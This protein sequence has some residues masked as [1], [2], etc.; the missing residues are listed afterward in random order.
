MESEDDTAD[1]GYD[2][3]RTRCIRYLDNSCR[4]FTK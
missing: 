4:D 3:V 2:M 1:N